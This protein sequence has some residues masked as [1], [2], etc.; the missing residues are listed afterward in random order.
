MKKFGFLALLGAFAT[1][2]NAQFAI[3]N[4]V[5]ARVGDGAAGLTSSAA[6]VNIDQFTTSGSLV[7][8]TGIS[9]LTM[10]GS[11]TSEG[12]LTIVGYG[13]DASDV[14]NY[15][16]SFG[17]YSTVAGTAGSVVTTTNAR[18]AGVLRFNNTQ[19]TVDL[20]AG[21][22]PFSAGNI[23]GVTFNGVTNTY[24]GVGS[25]TG[26][27]RADGTGASTV[28][29]TTTTNIRTIQYFGND[30]FYG[31]GSGTTRGVYMAA[32]AATGTG[33]TSETDLVPQ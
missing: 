33:I 32:G 1:A 16:I 6:A 22:T 18:R 27:V 4:V 15:G 30:A 26:V 24:F 2:A 14:T 10:S 9:N 25:N 3:G 21:T 11:A 7:N 13:G 29:S 23:R 19:S 12:Y 8:T 5:V 31:T 20:T 28:A 17:G